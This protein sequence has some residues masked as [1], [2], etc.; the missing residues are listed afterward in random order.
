MTATTTLPD[1]TKQA[2]NETT[3]EWEDMKAEITCS[4][5]RELFI[6]LFVTADLANGCGTA[7]PVALTRKEELLRHVNES[8]AR[9][10]E[11]YDACV[12]ELGWEEPTEPV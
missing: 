7:S 12:S 4:I 8:A 2:F 9:A 6:Q 10:G 11:A 1:G 5:S 3:Q